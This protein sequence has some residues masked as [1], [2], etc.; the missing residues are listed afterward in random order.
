MPQWV[1]H[2]ARKIISDEKKG[3]LAHL[4]EEYHRY[5][6]FGVS[7]SPGNSET[8]T[9]IGILL[10]L[11]ISIALSMYLIYGTVQAAGSL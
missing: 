10:F 2:Y 1:R 11:V 6:T 5:D 8:A 9:V 4:S 3:D 7:P